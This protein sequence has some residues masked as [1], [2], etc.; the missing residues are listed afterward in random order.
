MAILRAAAMVELALN[1]VIEQELKE[2]SNVSISVLV[3]VLRLCNGPR[4]KSQ[5]CKSFDTARPALE[6]ARR[7]YQKSFYKLLEKRN[8]I[9]HS[10]QFA[11]T[12]TAFARLS[13]AREMSMALIAVYDSEFELKELNRDEASS[14]A[15]R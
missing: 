1:Y 7:K 3:A 6:L 11:G 9:A 13:E 4:Q 12:A 2:R 8:G 15:R 5:L 14:S 10:G